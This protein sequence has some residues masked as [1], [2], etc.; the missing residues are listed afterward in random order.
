M[1][2]G[3]ARLPLATCACDFAANQ[4]NTMKA[5]LASG[6]SE[7]TIVGDYVTR[8]GREALTVP[9]DQGHNKALY[10]VPVAA[11]A[12]GAGIVFHLARKWARKPAPP[13]LTPASA[14]AKP[15]T[16]GAYDA[17]IDEE[18]RCLDE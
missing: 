13:T 6:D 11:L 2:G 5:R 9:P 15:E 4:R 18:L 7:A 17:R 8:Y 12:A 10:I 1:C 16:P 14:E 3:C